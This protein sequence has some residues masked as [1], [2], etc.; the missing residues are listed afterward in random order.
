MRAL[1]VALPGPGGRGPPARSRRGAPGGPTTP[2]FGEG[3]PSGLDLAR[4]GMRRSHGGRALALNT[5]R[6]ARRRLPRQNGEGPEARGPGKGDQPPHAYPAHP[7][8]LDDRAVSGA[9]GSA[10]K[11][12]GRARGTT[13]A[14]HG[15]VHPHHQWLRRGE[16]AHAQRQ[17]QPCP[18]EAG[19]DS[20]VQDAM[21]RLQRCPLCQPQHSLRR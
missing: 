21:R 18:L 16:G 9:H 7:A 6:R 8:S 13:A 10:V 12:C 20:V 5:R 19:P 1:A 15:L 4:L 3:P 17:A 11:P 2:R 14:L